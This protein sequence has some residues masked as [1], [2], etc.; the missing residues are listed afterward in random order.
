MECGERTVADYRIEAQLGAGRHGVTYRATGPDGQPVALR[1]FELWDATRA[2]AV[3]HDPELERLTRTLSNLQHV[4]LASN[5]G[6]FAH[7]TRVYVAEEFIEL[8]TLAELL[9]DDGPLPVDEA[10]AVSC[11]VLSALEFAHLRGVLHLDIRPE[12]VHYEPRFRQV[13]V[14]DTGHMQLLLRLRPGAALVDFVDE[15][16]APE[17]HV[18]EEP[19]AASEV[20]GVAALLHRMLTGLLPPRPDLQRDNGGGRFAFLEVEREKAERAPEDILAE[21]AEEAPGVIAVMQRALAVDPRERYDRAGRMQ[22]ALARAH[23]ADQRGEPY[24]E[25]GIADRA[26]EDGLVERERQF[27]AE[28][29]PVSEGVEFCEICGRPLDASGSCRTCGT[30]SASG[31]PVISLPPQRRQPSSFFQRHGDKLLVQERFDEAVDAY[32]MAV[33]RAPDDPEANRDL[34]DALALAQRYE[35]A[36]EAYQRVLKTTPDDLEARH[37]R[38]RML[39]A[40]GR[41]REAVYELRK[42]LAADPD[43]GIRRSALTQLGAAHAGLRNYRRARE[44]WERVLE[45]EPENARV[46]VLMART[47]LAQHN[48][49]AAHR[50]LRQALRTDP[51]DGR[52]RDLLTE[53]NRQL[54]TMGRN[55]RPTFAPIDA[56][57]ESG[58]PGVLEDA[59]RGAR[60][61]LGLDRREPFGGGGRSIPTEDGDTEEDER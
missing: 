10:W 6:T 8:P 42:V 22:Q 2:E 46:H 23:R 34:A 60:L 32:R 21:V 54:E 25:P 31:G 51:D 20:F 38:G 57:M 44:T 29:R 7:G 56:E 33:E 19:T 14:T 12:H 61:L 58:G 11:Q 53:V 18:G 9:E 55:G 30:R 26:A 40:A 47:Y 24:I 36:A 49:S 39:V 4:G 45:E 50:H 37:E 43:D 52:V 35:E 5:L 1:E 15:Y 48:L 59:L 13:V 16:H 28:R 3:H 27:E 17:L 41:H